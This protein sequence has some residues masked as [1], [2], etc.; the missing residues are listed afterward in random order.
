ML[1]NFIEF[2][3]KLDGQFGD[4]ELEVPEEGDPSIATPSG[5]PAATGKTADRYKEKAADDLEH[6]NFADI[7]S[8]AVRAVKDL[9]K[10]EYHEPRYDVLEEKVTYSMKYYLTPKKEI[11]A[12]LLNLAADIKKICG[13][14]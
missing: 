6:L 9:R 5:K 7:K 12:Q 13:D 4:G 8:V 10:N 14:R 2:V 1:I 11:N 3:V